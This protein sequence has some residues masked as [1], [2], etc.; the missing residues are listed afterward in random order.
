[1]SAVPTQK[2]TVDEFL[3]WAVDQPGRYELYAEPFMRWRQRGLV[4][5]L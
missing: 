1:M 4:M 2:L 3:A 5:L